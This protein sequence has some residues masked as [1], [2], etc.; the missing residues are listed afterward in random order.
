MNQNMNDT[1][2][3]CHIS[4]GSK[5]GWS[6]GPSLP[7]PLQ[8]HQIVP[9]GGPVVYWKTH[10][11]RTVFKKKLVGTDHFYA[12]VSFSVYVMK[13]CSNALYKKR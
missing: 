12:F 13:D 6:C 7:K 4:Q 1:P 8:D 9:G 10:H 5:L 2:V 11:K 3:A